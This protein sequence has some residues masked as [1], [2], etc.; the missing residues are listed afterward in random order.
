VHVR[1][2]NNLAQQPSTTRLIVQLADV[3]IIAIGTLGSHSSFQV[4]RLAKDFV[5]PAG[6]YP[7]GMTPLFHSPEE[8]GREPQSASSDNTPYSH[9]SLPWMIG[10]PM[11]R[12]ITMDP[13]PPSQHSS[14]H[15]LWRRFRSG[16]Y[17][18]KQ[19][20]HYV[21]TPAPLF[22]SPPPL[23]IKPSPPAPTRHPP[24]T[25]P[26]PVEGHRDFPNYTPGGQDL[27]WPESYDGTSDECWV[28]PMLFVP[29][30]RLSS[31][32]LTT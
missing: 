22:T 27:R 8:E 24:L 18:E 32:I 26:Q 30:I 14:R 10:T 29:S 21:D 12:S 5:H 9:T 31:S 15:S 11:T 13:T 1:D 17:S 2:Q 23:D 28:G 16:N 4:N 20:P 25:R 6:V 19:V 3:R 7:R